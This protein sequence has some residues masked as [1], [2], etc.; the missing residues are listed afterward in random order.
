MHPMPPDRPKPELVPP[1]VVPKP[2]SKPTRPARPAPVIATLWKTIGTVTCTHAGGIPEK[3][4]VHPLPV[5][6]GDALRTLQDGAAG[7]LLPR[8]EE[9]VLAGSSSAVL[10]RT[11][12]SLVA[13]LESGGLYARWPEGSGQFMVTTPAG[14]VTT[15]G[16]EIV[17]HLDGE[18]ATVTLGSGKAEVS[19]GKRKRTLSPGQSLAFRT[20]RALRAPRAVNPVPA[21]V[22]GRA[23]SFYRDAFDGDRPD[24]FRWRTIDPAGLVS[25]KAGRLVFHQ[26][27]PDPAGASMVR[28]AFRLSGDFEV[29]VDFSLPAWTAPPDRQERNKHYALLVLA[30]PDGAERNEVWLGRLQTS[31]LDAYKYLEFVG[32]GWRNTKLPRTSDRSGRLRFVREADRTSAYI[33]EGSSW[34]LLESSDLLGAADLTVGLMVQKGSGALTVEWDNFAVLRGRALR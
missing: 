23:R 21:L 31:G 32:N 5:R 18:E 9:L 34:Q 12:E 22:W 7:V 3:V 4:T 33:R 30:R 2:P 1:E 25:Q 20:G 13:S 24:P 15:S 8:G 17:L 16:A 28:S 14:S 10:R 26:D 29:Q 27:R 6:E 19:R 11:G